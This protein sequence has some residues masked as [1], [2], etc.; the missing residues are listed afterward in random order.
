MTPSTFKQTGQQVCHW[1][2]CSNPTHVSDSIHMPCLCSLCF[3]LPPPFNT[4]K[5]TLQ[6]LLKHMGASLPATEIPPKT[7]VGTTVTGN[8]AGWKLIVLQFHQGCYSLNKAWNCEMKYGLKSCLCPSIHAQK[9]TLPAR[10]CWPRGKLAHL[11]TTSHLTVQN[12]VVDSVYL[13]MCSSARGG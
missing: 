5:K 1:A 2:N 12:K 8:H 3:Q 6:G 9:C 10:Y 7:H 11:W 4:K 13:S